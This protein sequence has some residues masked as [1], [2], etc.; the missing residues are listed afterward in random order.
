M[1]SHPIQLENQGKC[2]HV[3]MLLPAFWLFYSEVNPDEKSCWAP[4]QG[5]PPSAV[6][7]GIQSPPPK[8]WFLLRR[9]WSR[10]NDGHNECNRRCWA[11]CCDHKQG[12]YWSLELSDSDSTEIVWS[13]VDWSRSARSP[14]SAPLSAP[15]S[16]E[17]HWERQ[18]W[19]WVA[20]WRDRRAA[21]ARSEGLLAMAKPSS[22]F[23]SWTLDFIRYRLHFLTENN[24][25]GTKIINICI[26]YI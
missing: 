16:E 4:T 20:L 3:T 25:Q 9:C 24:I 22:P 6:F 5:P 12:K 8:I 17:P 2:R 11:H 21:A 26:Y 10:T 23:L 7:E 14:P 13:P 18:D 19:M 15:A 1:N